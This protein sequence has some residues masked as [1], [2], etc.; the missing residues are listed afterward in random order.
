MIADR[1]EN[2][3]NFEEPVIVIVVV[4]AGGNTK[5]SVS[6]SDSVCRSQE[7]VSSGL[8]IYLQVGAGLRPALAQRRTT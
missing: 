2:S 6:V 4:V 7:A 1:P 8:G 3:S 5:T